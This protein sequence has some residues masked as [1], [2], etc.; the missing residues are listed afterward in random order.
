MDIYQT[1][2]RIEKFLGETID[3]FIPE[4][5]AKTIHKILDKVESHFENH[6]EALPEEEVKHE[7]ESTDVRSEQSSTTD[8]PASEER[9]S[10][11]NTEPTAGTDSSPDDATTTAS[12]K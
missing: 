3:H 12:P 4:V 9:Q 6:L 2:E 8:I 7:Y 11:P 1:K 5:Y 10:E